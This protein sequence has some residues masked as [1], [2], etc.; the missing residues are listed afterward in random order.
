[1]A[2][3]KFGTP[4]AA[5]EDP[6]VRRTNHRFI[7]SAMGNVATNDMEKKPAGV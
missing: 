7:H 5:S 2:L 6:A 1:H 4:C 3:P